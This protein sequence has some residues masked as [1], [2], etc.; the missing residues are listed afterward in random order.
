MDPGL[1]GH[2]TCMD[3]FHPLLSSFYK[4][5]TIQPSKGRKKR[6]VDGHAIRD[7]LIETD[8]SIVIIEKVGASPRMGSA[9]AWSF[10]TSYTMLIG[11]C[12]GMDL[13]YA[14]ITPQKWKSFHGLLKKDKDDSRLKIISLFPKLKPEFTLKKDVDKAESFLIGL[15]WW[16]I[17]CK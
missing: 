10:A 7:I 17:N 1:D 2:I 11:I 4:M 8:P 3:S 5:P 13:D 14:L 12:I 16:G 15:A 9:S 6:V